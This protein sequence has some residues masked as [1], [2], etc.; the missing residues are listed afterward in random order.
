M[1]AT[2][3]GDQ[4][5][6]LAHGCD[7]AANHACSA[8]GTAK[9]CSP[10][11]QKA[12]W[13]AR[14]K[15]ACAIVSVARSKFR[16]PDGTVYDGEFK[17]GTMD[18]KGRMTFSDGMFYEGDLI[19]GKPHGK[20]RTVGTDGIIYEG[21]FKQGKRHGKGKVTMPDGRAFESSWADDLPSSAP[22]QVP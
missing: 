10:E 15:A 5:L 17:K 13:K 18:G 4:V 2:S 3:S 9:Y 12:D 19:A 14:H 6:C 20:G 7:K 1:S 21:D 8:C 11:C 16:R 22:V